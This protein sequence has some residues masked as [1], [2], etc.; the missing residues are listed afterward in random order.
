MYSASAPLS[1]PTKQLVA[2]AKARNYGLKCPPSSPGEYCTDG[3]VI[4]RGGVFPEGLQPPGL[5]GWSR[6]LALEPVELGPLLGPDSEIRTHLP[7]DEAPHHLVSALLI[8]EDKKSYEHWG[9]ISVA[10]V[11]ADCEHQA[12]VRKVP[13]PLPYGP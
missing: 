1:L 4:P 9:V 10:F 5:N 11:R 13:A 6:N 3:T 12:E 2:Q 7:L 8:S